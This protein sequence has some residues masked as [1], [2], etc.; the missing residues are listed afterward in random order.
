MQTGKSGRL[1]QAWRRLNT[2]T[3]GTDA[4]PVDR[5]SKCGLLLAIWRPSSLDTREV[6]PWM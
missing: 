1:A 2:N 4:V 3:I 5:A 6:A